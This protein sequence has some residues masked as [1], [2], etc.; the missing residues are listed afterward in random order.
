[1]LATVTVQER[2]PAGA[3]AVLLNSILTYSDT[4]LAIDAA[5]DQL[6]RAIDGRCIKE[7]L[8]VAGQS[9]D[10]PSKRERARQLFEGRLR[11]DRIVLSAFSG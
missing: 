11:C 5:E 9:P 8:G 4:F 3:E 6:F 2:L 7:I 1:M 10:D